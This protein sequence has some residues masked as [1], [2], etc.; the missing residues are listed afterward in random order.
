[1][2]QTLRRQLKRVGITDPLSL[3][4]AEQWAALQ[5]AFSDTYTAYDSDRYTLERSLDISS[6]EMQELYANLEKSSRSQLAQER[7]RL[8]AI[9]SNIGDGV[10][11]L[12]PDGRIVL[13]NPPAREMLGLGTD[14][15]TDHDIRGH[16][17]GDALRRLEGL[18]QST[19]F[20]NTLRDERGEFCRQGGTLIPVSYVVTK[21]IFGGELLGFVL[22]FRDMTEQLAT[23]RSLDL[24]RQEAERA[25]RAKSEFL[26]SMSHEL[27]TP[28]HAVLGFA[29][30]LEY[31]DLNAEE[32]EH[33]QEILR[34]GGH[35][36]EL[37]NRVLDLAKIESGKLELSLGAVALGPVIEECASMV[38]NY[39]TVRDIR[40]S[41]PEAIDLF[42]LADRTRL[43]QC[44]LNLLSNAVKY[45]RDDGRVKLTVTTGEGQRVRIAVSDTG[46][47]IDANH[48][49]EVFQAFNRL[50]AGST[51][52]E[53][54]G[55]GL[56]ITRQL[57]E[58][59]GGS[60]AVRSEPG[61]GSTFTI[62]LAAA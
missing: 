51:N 24:A 38:R 16:L 3:P 10:C 13:S 31:E 40:F 55:I 6:R 28:M 11:F 42:V 22:L 61:D 58:L 14:E 12:D 62:E 49:E 47:G 15:I 60:I 19:A 17:S 27:R 39:P 46:T 35:L 30:L 53:G 18:I 37:I 44:L 33:V 5:K 8:R 41:F 48:L 7:D 25:S 34:A 43:K 54:T 23:M 56:T 32:R 26:S 2:H 9:I 20:N 57:V 52:V 4:N 1:M 59:M 21:L 29:Q 50:K 45:N 36:L